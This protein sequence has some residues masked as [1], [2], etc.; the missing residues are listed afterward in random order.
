MKDLLTNPR[1]YQGN[2]A[3]CFLFC[4]CAL[5]MPPE[6][7]LES[8]GKTVA[9]HGDIKRG[10]IDIE[11]YTEEAVIHWNGPPPTQAKGICIAA[12]KAVFGA[13]WK[14]AFQHQVDCTEQGRGRKR[15]AFVASATVARLRRQK[16]KLA[17]LADGA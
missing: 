2:E 4:H 15:K 11:T 8:M 9:D 16:P 6:S 1:F 12:L 14:T 3:W 7:V 17:F 13:R 10:N 5:K